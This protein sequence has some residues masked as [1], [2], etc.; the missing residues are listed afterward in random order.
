[1]QAEGQKELQRL[2][3]ER[4]SQPWE[5]MTSLNVPRQKTDPRLL[6]NL[7]EALRAS[8][9][10]KPAVKEKS[11]L[12][13]LEHYNLVI[14]DKLSNLGLLFVGRRQDRARLGTAPLLQAVKYD[15]HGHKIN[16]WS[17]DDHSLSPPEIIDSVWQSIPDFQESYEI[18]DGLRRRNIPAYDE[19]VVRELLVNAFVHRPYNQGGEIFLNL[20]PDRL[21]L[22]NPGRLP[23]GVTPSNILHASRRRNNELARLFHDLGL[24]EREGSGFDLIYELLLLHG[25]ATPQ[26]EE[27]PDW[28]K[29]SVAR[30]ILDLPGMRLL[31]RLNAEF[32][33]SQRERISLG[34]LSRADSLSA[35]E[36]AEQ[37]E[38]SSTAALPDWLGRLAELNI[39]RRQQNQD[40][41]QPRYSLHPEIL[42]RFSNSSQNT[43]NNH[44]RPSLIK[45]PT[46]YYQT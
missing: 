34:L 5:T 16:K 20:H 26:L 32:G 9:R 44:Q 27:G 25:R 11:T 15:S 46:H 2:L 22:V 12:E 6:E 33:L 36:L 42:S 7:A 37:L 29:V 8:E 23:M 39:I 41:D 14:E 28:L 4:A 13:L 30:Q 10:V 24:M 1:M 31:A 18:A 17:W 40:Q 45:E 21:E 3:N 43:A 35:A 19:S 38:L